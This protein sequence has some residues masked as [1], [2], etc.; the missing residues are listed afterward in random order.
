MTFSRTL[1]F[2][3]PLQLSSAIQAADTEVLPATKGDFRAD[4]S[5]VRFSKLWMSRFKVDTAH[6]SIS[7]M[8]RSRRIV[9]FVTEGTKSALHHCG[10]D[11][12]H[13]DLIAARFDVSHQRAD[14]GLQSGAM[15]LPADEFRT[16]C[17]TIIGR[18]LP[19]T[20][21]S[22]IVRPDS[23]LMSR[24][25]KLHRTAGQLAHDSP[26]ILVLPEVARALEHELTLAMVRC[27]ASG[28]AIALG[29]RTYRHKAVIN[30]FE[31][32]LAAN[33]DRPLYLA[34]ICAAIGV[35]E[36]TL[37]AACEE[38]MGMG[39]IRF[40]TLRRMNLVRAAL[41]RARPSDMTVTRVLTDHGFWEFGR[42][43]AAYRKLF[44][45]LPSAT[46][47]RPAQEFAIQL[48]RPTTLAV[49]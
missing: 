36:R 30:R 17:K 20:P 35:A 32:F 45:E 48:G 14:A 4:F 29:K 11:V 24:L 23:G 49:L 8:S 22:H 2:G 6:T 12:T 38:F 31:E 1:S 28:Q 44:G 42:F 5:H 43:S 33:P 46:L 19:D 15:S 40:L 10:V 7:A 26:D 25:L 9:G 27:L 34:E 13:G 21:G 16:I 37:R 18:D 41:L 47:Q 39:P 3:D